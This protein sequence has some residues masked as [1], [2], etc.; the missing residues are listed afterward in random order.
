MVPTGPCNNIFP[1]QNWKWCMPHSQMPENFLVYWERV[2]STELWPIHLIALQ[3]C[4][5]WIKSI[6]CPNRVLRSRHCCFCLTVSLPIY[7]VTESWFS[8]RHHSS[9]IPQ[10]I[11]NEKQSSRIAWHP[12]SYHSPTGPH[13]A[14]LLAT[15]KRMSIMLCQVSIHF[16]LLWER[17]LI[18]PQETYASTVL[19]RGTRTKYHRLDGL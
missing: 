8:F 2:I 1:T 9:F 18:F 16:A 4:N 7:L 10:C 19:V 13:G 15:V 3:L 17:F 12:T 14:L 6:C 5:S 11:R